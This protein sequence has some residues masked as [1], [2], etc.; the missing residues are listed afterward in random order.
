[1]AKKQKVDPRTSEG[2]RVERRAWR[3]AVRRLLRKGQIDDALLRLKRFGE[4]RRRRYDARPG[5]LGR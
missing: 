1:M 3:D 5:G 2:A 4:E